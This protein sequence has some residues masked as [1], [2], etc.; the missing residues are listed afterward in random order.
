MFGHRDRK[1][2]VRVSGREGKTL[3]EVLEGLALKN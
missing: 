2:G 3:I 1:I